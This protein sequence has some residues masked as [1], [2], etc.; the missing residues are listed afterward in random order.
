MSTGDY[1]HEFGY[2]ST[3]E[4]GVLTQKMN[5]LRE[6]FATILRN[7]SSANKEINHAA[8]INQQ[9]VDNTV[10][11]IKSQQDMSDTVAASVDDLKS[12]G[13]QVADSAHQ[14]YQ[15][16]L[17]AGTAV[18]NGCQII[19][20]NIE[21]TR[22]LAEKMVDTVIGFQD[23]LRQDQEEEEA[24]AKGMENRRRRIEEDIEKGEAAL[25]ELEEEPQEIEHKKQLISN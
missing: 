15:I 4:F 20:D 8:A 23:I 10:K 25:N 3:N 9:S 7:I 22:R 21:A 14:T 24:I 1:T 12:T 11:G 16:V 13:A 6:Q 5:M 2:N 19:S 17:D 18:Q